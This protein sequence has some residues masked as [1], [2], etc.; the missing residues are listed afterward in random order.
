MTR[1]FRRDTDWFAALCRWLRRS[2][3]CPGPLGWAV[4]LLPDLVDRNL[5]LTDDS[6]Q[7][8]HALRWETDVPRNYAASAEHLW[9]LDRGAGS[10]LGI[11]VSAS[12]EGAVRA[13]SMLVAYR[14]GEAVEPWGTSQLERPP[15]DVCDRR[16]RTLVLGE[17]D[18]RSFADLVEAPYPIHLDVG[19][20]R[21]LGFPNVLVQ[22]LL[23]LLVVL[24]EFA[25]APA[26]EVEM[27][28]RRPVVAGSA[29]GVYAGPDGSGLRA[30]TL[31]GSGEVAAV[32]RVKG[33]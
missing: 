11:A 21:N 4:L 13:R 19:Y 12:A 20:A 18:V 1:S 27:W 26:G 28:F 29:L 17:D 23:L 10:E 14:P 25:D 5:R 30:V 15:E 3:A 32:A 16:R 7:L 9:L 22:G 2:V 31:V 33:A 6:L 8:F 24:D